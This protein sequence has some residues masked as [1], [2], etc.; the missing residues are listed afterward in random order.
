[1]GLPKS[2]DITRAQ[3]RVKESKEFKVSETTKPNLT[4]HNSP[5]E[6]LI[7]GFIRFSIG[8]LWFNFIKR[9][10]L[11]NKH[12]YAGHYITPF[13]F[14]LS[15]AFNIKTDKVLLYLFAQIFR[16]L[17]APLSCPLDLF[18]PTYG[19]SRICELSK[20]MCTNCLFKIAKPVLTMPLLIRLGS[21]LALIIYLAIQHGNAALGNLPLTKSF[22]TLDTD[23]YCFILVCRYL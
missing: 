21:L 2:G 5:I 6:K 15:K 11:I 23:C 8:E 12:C 18:R 17:R 4:R 7:N 14:K 3:L 22:V 13:S 16:V 19:T 1:M 9:G 10:P 20:K